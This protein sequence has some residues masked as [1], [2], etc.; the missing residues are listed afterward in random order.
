M[1]RT[2]VIEIDLAS[3]V[4]EKVIGR[5]CTWTNRMMRL[6]VSIER[7][8]GRLLRSQYSYGKT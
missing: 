4:Y 2:D 3:R 1:L 6:T 5:F 7:L 8:R